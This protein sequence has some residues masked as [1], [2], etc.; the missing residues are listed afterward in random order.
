MI[1][2]ADIAFTDI[3][4]SRDADAAVAELREAITNFNQLFRSLA[5]QHPGVVGLAGI[6]YVSIAN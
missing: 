2:A 1:K 6:C 3:V 5:R 4:Q